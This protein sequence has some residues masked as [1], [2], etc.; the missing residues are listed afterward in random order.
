MSYSSGNFLK[1]IGSDKNIKLYDDNG[2]LTYTVKPTLIT[3]VT[4]DTNLLKITLKSGKIITLDFINDSEPITAQSKLQQQ[5]ASL[6]QTNDYVDSATQSVTGYITAP[7][8]YSTFLR[9]ITESDRNIKILGIDL[10]VKY[11][12]DPFYIINT[13]INNNILK[14]N[15]KSKRVIT[16]DF[17]TTNESKLALILLREQI[18]ILIQKVPN[19]IDKQIENY[20]K[21]WSDNNLY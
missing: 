13:S 12:I 17:S 5:I 3:D 15:L 20:L 21:W 11:T 8:S 7:Y 4:P 1:P 9:P 6:L 2:S 18:D 10:I 19:L 16:L 14:I